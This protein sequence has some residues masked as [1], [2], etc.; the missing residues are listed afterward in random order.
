[1]MLSNHV[2]VEEEADFVFCILY[3]VFCILM[4]S[5]HIG[6]EKEADF[7]FVSFVFIFLLMLSNQMYMNEYN[8]YITLKDNGGY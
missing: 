4:L 8:P 3:F 5:N 1:M 6:V 2:G 7:V